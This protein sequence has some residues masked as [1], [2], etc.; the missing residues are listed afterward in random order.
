V[1]DCVT[2]VLTIRY[3]IC[4]VCEYSFWVQDGFT[5][6]HWA[7]FYGHVIL[8]D[9]LLDHGA[10]SLAKSGDDHATPLHFAVEEGH[11]AAALRFLVRGVSADVVDKVNPAIIC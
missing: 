4:L 1:C 11:V 10:N 3:L 2:E 9:M 5:P 7:G 6:L 8:I